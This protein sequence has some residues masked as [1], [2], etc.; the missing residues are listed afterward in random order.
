MKTVPVP[1]DFR[2][3][4]GAWGCIVAGIALLLVSWA[5][6]GGPPAL[7]DEQRREIEQALPA[8]AQVQ[9]AKPSARLSPAVLAQEKLGWRLGIEA[10]TFHKF[11]F[12]ETIEKTAELGLAYVGGLS[13]MQRVSKDIPKNFD[14]HLSDDELR[15][16]RLK[17][18]SGGVRLLTYYAQDIPGDEAGCRA[19]FEFGRTMGI[20]TFMCEP[21][22]EQLEL[23]DTLANE[24]GINV[25]MHNH[26]QN[27]S[28]QYWRPEG[29]LEVCEGRSMRI[30]AAPD[31]GYWL[32]SGIDPVEAVRL[33]KD[34]IITVQMHDL[35]EPGGNGHDVPWGTGIGKSQEFFRELHRQ[36]IKP[37]MIG[38]EYSYDWFES[39]PKIATCIEFFN[40]TTLRLAGEPP[41]PRIPATSAETV[42]DADGNTYHTVTIGHQVWTVE[43]LRTTKFNDGTPI[44]H[45]TDDA[46]WKGLTTPGFCYY[47]N[48]PEHGKKYGALYNWYAASSDKIAPKG[49]RV[50][51]HEQQMA[52]RD[53][54]IANGY[55][56]DGSTE[57][58]KVAKSMAAKTDWVYKPTNEGNDPV[59]DIGTVGKN[60]ETNN[61]SGFSA[62]PTGSRWNDGSFH[63]IGTSVYWWSTTPDSTPIKAHM[64]SVHTWFAKYG[65][66]QHHKRSGFCIRL[67]RDE[68]SKGGN[69]ATAQPASETQAKSFGDP[70]KIDV[71][72]VTGGHHFD[73]EP[74][75]A[76]F[77]GCDD[78]KY[79][80]H[81]LKDES[82]VFEDIGAWKYDVV[83]LYNM[84]QKISPKRQDN[85]VRLLK[86]KG[87]GVVV[88]HHAEAAFQS[89]PEFHQI[90]GTAYIYFDVEVDGKLWPHCKCKG[91]QD[92]AVAI[93]DDK[94]PITRGMKDFTIRDETYKGRWWAKDNHLLLTTKHPDNDEPVAWTRQYGRSRVFNIQFGH[95]K[96][97]YACPEYRVLL[98]RG[99]RWA[100]GTRSAADKPNVELRRTSGS[101]D[102]LADGRL[103][104]SYVYQID[105][106]KPLAAKGVL[107]TKPV[108]FPLRTPSGVSVTRGWPFEKIEGESEDH[109]HHAGLHFTYDQPNGNSFW[110]NSTQPLPAIKHIQAEVTTDAA[111]N[112][113]LAA[114]MHWIG[115]DNDALLVEKRLTS[116]IAG[117]DQYIIDFDIELKAIADT[118]EFGAT[119]EGMFAIRLAQWLTESGGTGAYLSSNGDEREQGVWG[120]RAEWVRIQGEHDGATVGIAILNHPTSTNY[121]TYWHTRGY[122]AFSANPLGQYA[123]EKS[124]KVENPRPFNLTLKKG[125]TAPFKF[126][127]ILYDGSRTKQQLDNEFREYAR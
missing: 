75:F 17:M 66:N 120:K 38:L 4:S 59:P 43:N 40:A 111:G 70:D 90:I 60:P 123:F 39:M 45:V 35:H 113:A 80:E 12:L 22:P 55:N 121:P 122:G 34:R 10:Y 20:E 14:Q 74:F 118:V 127:V 78:I 31:L 86:D 24:Y 97:A 82:E 89:W 51:T 105:P 71:L 48:N 58:N 107:L 56:Y 94:H 124:R 30:G 93:R 96:Q 115:K 112:P 65:N 8:K 102:V 84:T 76:M 68:G 46:G 114:V 57:G 85:F 106:V 110:N 125:E 126:R 18:E 25:A 72:V 101:I 33:L 50:P 54:L 98:V 47:E 36:G 109:P 95:D 108:L 73:P 13:F 21:K 3:G 15:Q 6:A 7:T 2:M 116:F 5:N 92:I 69:A 61:R 27:I 42:E 104:T 91:G 29:V 83:L 67:I 100:V 49:W 26:G 41:N 99:I 9:P 117:R 16:I 53:S 32:R 79:L 19:L 64:S 44:P 52:L 119:K 88:V 23:L 87:V 37:T 62:L 77:E 63:A 11:T 103:F 81:P 28:P 1:A